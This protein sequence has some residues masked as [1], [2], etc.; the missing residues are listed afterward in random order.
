M[1]KAYTKLEE[2]QQEIKELE[3]QILDLKKKRAEQELSPSEEVELEQFTEKLTE[4][5]AVQKDWMDII[6]SGTNKETEYHGVYN[7]LTIGY[8][9]VNGIIRD[10]LKVKGVRSRMYQNADTYLG[11][12]EAG[13]PAF[14]YEENGTTLRINVLFES[15]ENALKFDSHLRNESITINSPLNSLAIDSEV[16]TNSAF[17]LG[18]RIYY[19]DYIPTESESPQETQS[20]VTVQFSTIE[21]YKDEFKYQ[22]IEKL[23]IFGSLGKADSCHIMSKEHCNNYYSTY[24]KYNKDPSNRIALSRE[25][26]GWFDNNLGAEIPL[27]YL[28]V[29]NISETPIVEDRYRIV[30][31]VIVVNLEYADKIFSR[32]IEGSTQTDNPRIMNTFVYIKNPKIFQKCLEWKEKENTKKWADYYSMDSAVP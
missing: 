8:W 4:L 19:K 18:T 7:S 22:R 24:G 2:V 20:V 17:Q 9:K 27:F 3:K 13:Q 30:L 23:S 12:Y 25:L 16:T 28:K 11:Y 1:E 21:Q 5:K 14:F 15:K 29:V 26:H 10:S 32:L 31:A 6:K